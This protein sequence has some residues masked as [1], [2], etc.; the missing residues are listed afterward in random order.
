MAMEGMPEEWVNKEGKRDKLERGCQ[1]S[2][3]IKR[4][5]EIN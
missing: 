5:S 3:L 2:G 1:R 4:I